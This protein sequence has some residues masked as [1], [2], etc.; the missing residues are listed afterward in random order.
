VQL[1]TSHQKALVQDLAKEY[2]VSA[3]PTFIAFLN[4]KKVG[5]VV[6]ANLTKM[7]EL[8][9]LCDLFFTSFTLESNSHCKKQ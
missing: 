9:A 3:M 1:T 5:D 8:I 2:Q 7:E 4:G 6:G